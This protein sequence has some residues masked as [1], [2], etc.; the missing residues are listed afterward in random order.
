MKDDG[1]EHGPKL[2]QSTASGCHSRTW[3]VSSVSM[4]RGDAAPWAETL[5]EDGRTMT[6]FWINPGANGRLAI[7]PRPRG[8]E[9]LAHDLAAI[10]RDGID[11]LVSLLTQP[12]TAELGLAH[13]QALCEAAGI[14]FRS[15][16]IPDRC[17]PDTYR[18]MHAL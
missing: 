4:R 6:V 11:I 7:V 10:R 14:E 3:K 9:W 12:E 1:P 15:F 8:S 17:V 5:T 13:E 2:R 18:D 16:P